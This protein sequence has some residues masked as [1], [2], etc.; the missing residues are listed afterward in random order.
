MGGKV[1]ELESERLRA[2]GEARGK[3]IGESIGEARGKAIGES[4]GKAIG[5]VR[6]EERLSVLINKLILDKRND[7]IQIVVEVMGGIEPARTYI[8]E[9]LQAGKNVVTANKDLMAVHGGELLDIASHNGCDLLFEASVAGGIPIIRPLKQCLAGNYISEAMGIVNGT[10]N[11][12]LT[13]M[14]HLSLIH[15]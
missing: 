2:E 9:A 6:G 11:F 4:I 12:I 7:E 3:A 13:K 14:T 5:E 8:T 10:T 15:I 1:L